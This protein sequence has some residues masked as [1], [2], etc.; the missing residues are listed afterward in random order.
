MQ[1]LLRHRLGRYLSIQTLT[2]KRQG[3]T[4]VSAQNSA[5][6]QT[7]TLFGTDEPPIHASWPVPFAGIDEAGRG[8][9]AGPVVAGAC[10]LPAPHCLDGLTDSK[11]LTEKRRE[12]LYPLIREH[13]V[14]WGIG[15]AWPREIDTVN[16]LQATFRA[17]YRA[18]ACMKTSPA[19]VAIDGNQLL[20]DTLIP[21][22]S[23]TGKPAGQ[24]AVIKGD[25]KV[26]CIS[27]AS[28]LAKTFRDRLM[29]RLDRRYP[30]YGFAKHKGYGTKD[31]LAAIAQHGPCPM[32]RM[33]FGGVCTRPETTEQAS[34]W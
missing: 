26:E 1:T 12:A 33:T 24:I 8:C 5:Q 19:F 32:H 23:A 16:I 28:I 10:I 25:L 18:V 29:V 22:C 7:L 14:A 9:L 31:H 4:P 3:V 2:L 27:A 11:K 13:A 20:P 6:E 34:L 30:A 21:I 17:M 15:V